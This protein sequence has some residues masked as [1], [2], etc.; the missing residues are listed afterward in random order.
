[1]F[2]EDQDLS[3]SEV[4]AENENGENGFLPETEDDAE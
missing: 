1:M 2:S 4:D 3:E